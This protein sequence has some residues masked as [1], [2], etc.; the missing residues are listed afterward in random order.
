MNTC[1]HLTDLT[2]HN[3]LHINGKMQSEFVIVLN[4][5][6]W[7]ATH[8]CADVLKFNSSALYLKL[9]GQSMVPWFQWCLWRRMNQC[10]R[11]GGQ[12]LMVGGP[13]EFPFQTSHFNF[14]SQNLFLKTSAAEISLGTQWQ[15]RINNTHRKVKGQSCC[16]LAQWSIFLIND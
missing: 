5:M 8:L 13:L 12:R 11:V 7:K 4:I 1:I 15:S 10:G 9:W 2:S 14:E 3:W 16:F 6:R